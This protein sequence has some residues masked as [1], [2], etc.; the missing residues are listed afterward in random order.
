MQPFFQTQVQPT[1]QQ[2]VPQLSTVTATTPA[3]SSVPR[4]TPVSA[5][6]RVVVSAAPPIKSEI[7]Q[8]KPQPPKSRIVAQ[9]PP[10]HQQQVAPAPPV[11]PRSSPPVQQPTPP[12]QVQQP[13]IQQQQQNVLQPAPQPPAPAP[14]AAPAP[15][16]AT[17]TITVGPDQQQV[18]YTVSG[19]DGKTQQYMMLCPKDM[20]QNT[21]ITTLVRQISA[22]PTNKG[23]K[24]IRITQHKSAP[25]GMLCLTK[26][27]HGHQKGGGARG[28]RGT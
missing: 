9:V 19:E 4:M 2:E 26:Q 12:L 18:F 16:T 14:P 13:Q 17:N 10:T 25:G 7:V 24:T 8:A 11:L 23:K 22:D 28:H 6:K 20:D 15:G 1:I 3:V 27:N 5:S 21:L